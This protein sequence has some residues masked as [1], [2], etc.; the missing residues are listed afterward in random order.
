[1]PEKEIQLTVGQLVDAVRT[2]ALARFFLVPR[3]TITVSHA[4]RKLPKA[5]QE[6]IDYY[7]T[8]VSEAE[9]KN[10]AR[11]LEIEANSASGI[12]T[13][14]LK[15]KRVSSLAA[16]DA[17]IEALRKRKLTLPGVRLTMKDLS[18]GG[19]CDPDYDLLTPFLDSES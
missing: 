7:N 5:C 14:E 2:G 15:E 9:G 16:F 17:D 8:S 6:E 1:M 10:T 4:N 13:E 19:L 3:T 11:L 12:S 18:G